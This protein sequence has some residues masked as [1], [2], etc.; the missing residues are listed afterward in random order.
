VVPLV[1]AGKSIADP[2]LPVDGGASIGFLSFI[3]DRF[4]SSSKWTM[5]RFSPGQIDM[6]YVIQM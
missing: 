6:T 2:V 1:K 4:G 3:P 5:L